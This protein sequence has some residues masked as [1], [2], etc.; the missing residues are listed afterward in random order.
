MSNPESPHGP[1]SGASPE[2]L[3]Q[4][5]AHLEEE[6]A[7]LRQQNTRLEEQVARLVERIEELER[8]LGLDSGNS[9]KPPSSDRLKKPKSKRRTRSLRG[10]S[11]RKPGGQPGHKG[12]TL[13]RADH[14]DR[15]KGL[16]AFF[17]Q[18]MRF[19]AFGRGQ[20]GNASR[21][22]G[23]RSAR[24]ASAGG[25]RAPGS[26]QVLRALR[27]GARAA[28]P[29]GVSAPV[30]YGPRIAGV[31][32]YLQHVRRAGDGCDA[33][34]DER[35]GSRA[36]AGRGLAH[37]GPGGGTAHMLIGSHPNGPVGVNISRRT[38]ATGATCTSG[39]Q[40]SNCSR[41]WS[42]RE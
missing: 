34:D 6:N 29:D 27:D 31:A 15:V 30:Q 4:K 22:P 28:F 1:S 20:G 39:K 2:T 19:V 24:A 16:C 12:E 3:A 33:G 38:L 26:W 35:E 36:A 9:G 25:D 21:P 41:S 7:W 40:D 5:N 14:P 13:R 32:V 37:T 8:R 23:V 17:L 11:G 18:G 42:A 10:K